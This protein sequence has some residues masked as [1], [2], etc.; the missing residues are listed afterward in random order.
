MEF[1]Q[2][3]EDYLTDK[4]KN[5]LEKIVIHW[6]WQWRHLTHNTWHATDAVQRRKPSLQNHIRNQ[7]VE[8]L[9]YQIKVA[10]QKEKKKT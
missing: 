6:H 10:D 2:K 9:L 8:D 7:L 4:G 5:G 3:L 1:Y